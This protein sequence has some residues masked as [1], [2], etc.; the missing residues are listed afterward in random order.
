MKAI[1][2]KNITAIGVVSLLMLSACNDDNDD[3]SDVV[4]TMTETV[5]ET[6]THTYSVTIT[7]LTQGQPMSPFVLLA[8]DEGMLFNIGDSASESLEYIAEGGN[9]SM[10]LAEDWVNESTTASAMLMPGES[11]TLMLENL[12]MMPNYLSVA[13]MLVVTNDG[14]TAV[15]AFD[16]SMLN[17]G[18]SYTLMGSVYDA[19]TEM[20]SEMAGTIPGIDMGEGFNSAREIE[21][22]VTIHPGVV[23]M[24]DGLTQSVLTSFH[25]FDNPA[26]KVVINKM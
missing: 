4:D 7:N 18:E 2:T 20:N 8:H 25:R 15:N 10:L 3:M 5:T 1:N 11:V 9:S 24:Y 16:T 21:G 26:I 12:E 14:F 17:S 22:V 23:S 13:S 6:M 19:G